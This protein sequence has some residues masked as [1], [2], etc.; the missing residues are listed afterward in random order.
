M[1]NTKLIK[2]ENNKFNVVDTRNNKVVA[3]DLKG[4][5]A[6]AYREYYE[7]QITEAELFWDKY[8]GDL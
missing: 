8:Q 6:V 4:S 2:N 3:R 7:Q 1:A 5:K